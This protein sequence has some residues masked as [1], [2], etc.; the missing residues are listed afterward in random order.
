[1]SANTQSK[2]ALNQ[3]GKTMPATGILYNNNILKLALKHTNKIV[4]NTLQSKNKYCC[5]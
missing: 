4:F 2:P 1:M 3:C 5:M